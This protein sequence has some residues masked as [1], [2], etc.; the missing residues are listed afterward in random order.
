[1]SQENFFLSD[2]HTHLDQYSSEELDQILARAREAHLSLIVS[3]GTTLESSQACV[4]L[5]QKHDFIFAGVGIHP[6]DLKGMVDEALYSSLKS[7]AQK[8]PKAVCVSEIGLDF[9]PTS[10]PKEI[11]RQAFREQIRLAREIHLPIIFHAR[12]D[13]F[14]T[15]EILREEK[16]HEIGGAIHYFQGDEKSAKS[17]LDLGFFISLAKPLLR[18]PELQEVVRALPLD[19]LLLETDSFPQP[20]KKYRRNWTEPYHVIQVARK[21]A[22]L[23]QISIEEVAS[24]TTSNLKN[25]LHINS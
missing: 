21:V 1:M 19:R 7:L 3:A 2:A 9:L 20:W 11:Q 6:M 4:E 17:V 23:K 15:L 25:L 10:P 14:E 8:S 13:H 16:A 18:L 24:F 22:E 5:A 12:E